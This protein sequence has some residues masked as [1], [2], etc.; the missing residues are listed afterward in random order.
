MDVVRAIA[1]VPRDG[2]D[3]PRQPVQIDSIEI[4]RG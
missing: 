2:R 1:R 4:I 3:R